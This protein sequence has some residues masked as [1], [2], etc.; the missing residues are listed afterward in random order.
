MSNGLRD[1]ITSKSFTM[2]MSSHGTTYGIAQEKTSR[3]NN[4]IIDAQRMCVAIRR[5]FNIAPRP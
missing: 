5:D 3:S 1:S 2:K 4:F